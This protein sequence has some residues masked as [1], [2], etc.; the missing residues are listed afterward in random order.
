MPVVDTNGPVL[1]EAELKATGIPYKKVPKTGALKT[2]LVDVQAHLNATHKQ[3]LD[4]H[5]A[6]LQATSPA[7]HVPLNNEQKGAYL[8]HSLAQDAIS[9]LHED[10][11]REWYGPHAR[12]FE[13]GLHLAF[14][15]PRDR[16]HPHQVLSKVLLGLTSNGQNPNLNV[17]SVYR[18]LE[19]AGGDPAA[20]GE[21]RHGD[22]RAWADKHYGSS[23]PQKPKTLPSE[24]PEGVSHLDHLARWAVINGLHRNPGAYQ[25]LPALMQT[26][27]HRITHVEKYGKLI[28]VPGTRGKGTLKVEA[29]IPDATGNLTPKNWIMRAGS[30]KSGLRMLHALV[31]DKGAEGAAQFLTSEHELATVKAARKKYSGGKLSNVPKYLPAGTSVAG[32]LMFGPKIGSYMANIHDDERLGKYL[33]ADMWFGRNFRR[34][35]GTIKGGS[36]PIDN[37]PDRAQMYHHMQTVLDFMRGQGHKVSS[38]AQLQALLWYQEQKLYRRYHQKAESGNLRDGTKLALKKRGLTLPGA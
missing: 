31:A 20:V 1:T 15:F 27:T 9:G 26:R 12:D 24:P 6:R 29:P 2:K 35:T 21:L 18:M 10:D 11:A 8:L 25:T 28:R 5:L 33:T 37:G 34:H 36:E 19:D 13:H 16:D 17:E 7:H 22:L 38:I 4:D 32:F 14:G 3:A 23:T 30:V